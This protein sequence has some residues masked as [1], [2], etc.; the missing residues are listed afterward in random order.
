MNHQ[1]IKQLIEDAAAEGKKLPKTVTAHVRTCAE[2]RL[3]YAALKELAKPAAIKVPYGFELG[4]WR[5]V[6]APAAE[7]AFNIFPALKWAAATAAA[8]A[9][10]IMSSVTLKNTTPQ[11]ASVPEKAKAVAVKE[12]V[13]PAVVTAKKEAVKE[14]TAPIEQAKAPE[15]KQEAVKPFE[16]ATFEHAALSGQ[17]P[18]LAPAMAPG[19]VQS[20]AQMSAAAAKVSAA[21]VVDAQ[22]ASKGEDT[23]PIIPKNT[24]FNPNRQEVFTAAYSVGTYTKVEITI[25]NRRGATVRHLLNEE[26]APGNYENSWDGKDDAGMPVS[27][28]IYMVHV[29][30]DIAEEKIKVVVVK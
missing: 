17:G 13:K 26:K 3:E 2:C 15:A 19:A 10:I 4:I 20:G 24:V 25:I 7:A 28:G 9:I 29:K 11:L 30:T 21:E 27:A 23:R 22:A 12:A 6:D 1:Q 18:S 14:T 5:K 16:P 8:I